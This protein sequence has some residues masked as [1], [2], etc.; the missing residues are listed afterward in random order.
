[1]LD[2]A[3]REI[4][5]DAVSYFLA[6]GQEVVANATSDVQDDVIPPELRVLSYKPEPVFEQPLRVAVLLI[7]SRAGALIEEGPDVG[8]VVYARGREALKSRTKPSSVFAGRLPRQSIRQTCCCWIT[9]G[10]G[11]PTARRVHGRGSSYTATRWRKTISPPFQPVNSN[12]QTA[13]RERISPSGTTALV[14]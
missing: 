14:P 7:K 8:G 13:T 1:N 12:M 9:R 3:W 11:H 5:S 2:H 6:Q 10:V 4:D